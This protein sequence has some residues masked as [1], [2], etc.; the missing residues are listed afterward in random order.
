M[1]GRRAGLGKMLE[2]RGSFKEV[3]LGSWRQEGLTR[4]P[5]NRKERK[6]QSLLVVPHGALVIGYLRGARENHFGVCDITT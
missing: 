1:L 4:R 5:E 6:L 2:R 3:N